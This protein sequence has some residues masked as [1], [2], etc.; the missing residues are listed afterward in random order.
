MEAGIIMC[1]FGV[2]GYRGILESNME[3]TIMGHWGFWGL[4]LRL[5]VPVFRLASLIT[6]K[7][8]RAQSK[9][10]CHARGGSRVVLLA[11]EGLYSPP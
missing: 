7:L 3:M 2:Y 9:V 1:S 5:W 4:G 8:L 6:L 10:R 11:T